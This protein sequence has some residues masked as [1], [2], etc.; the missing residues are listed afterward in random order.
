MKALQ[1]SR[2]FGLAPS[3]GIELLSDE[4]AST[5]EPLAIDDLKLRSAFK[6]SSPVGQLSPLR[7]PLRQF[8]ATRVHSLKQSL[9]VRNPCPRRAHGI[10]KPSPLGFRLI[11]QAS[12]VLAGRTLAESNTKLLGTLARSSLAAGELARG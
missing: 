1:E 3:R 7:L 12:N 11:E 5:I 8:S 2:E 10:I 9:D 6:T 4:R